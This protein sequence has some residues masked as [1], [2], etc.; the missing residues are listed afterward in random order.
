[1]SKRLFLIG[2]DEFRMMLC[3]HVINQILGL[4][5]PVYT[6]VCLRT[7]LLKSQ[8]VCLLLIPDHLWKS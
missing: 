1:M 6:S 4:D 2:S 5:S 8:S 3:Y 7:D